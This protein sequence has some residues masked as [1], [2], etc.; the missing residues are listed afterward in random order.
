MSVLDAAIMVG[1]ESTYGAVVALTRAFEGKAD[2]FKREQVRLESVGMFANLQAQRSANVVEIDMGGTGSLELDVMRNGFGQLLTSLLGTTV[3]P[4]QQAATTAYLQTF[5]SDDAGSAVSYTIQHIRPEIVA[6]QQY[7]HVGC[8]TTGW[9]LSQTVGGLCLLNMDFDFQD[10]ETSTAA[11]SPVYVAGSPYNWTQA[12]FEVDSVEVDIKSFEFT[13]DLAM[14]TDRRY[15]SA[16]GDIAPLKSAPIRRGL[17]EYSGSVAIDVV[18]T[19]RYDEWVAGT[20]VALDMTW[21]GALIETPHN[22]ELKL[23][24]PEAVWTG[25][26]PEASI[27][28]LTTQALPFKVL[29]ADSGAAVTLTY[30]ATDTA[31]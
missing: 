4:I 10:S 7:T 9:K 16:A 17:P 26:S 14:H 30:M 11:G 21:T 15:M 23:S 28:D 29:W 2:T 20:V 5:T 13:A 3:G 1:T 8:V 22:Y 31:L 27:S 24:I 25:E 18:D 12:K 19:A 6:T